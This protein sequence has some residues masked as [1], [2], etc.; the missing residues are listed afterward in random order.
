MLTPEMLTHLFRQPLKAQVHLL[1]KVTNYDV[2]DL[3][4]AASNIWRFPRVLQPP[5]N[6]S[7]EVNRGSDFSRKHVGSA[8]SEANMNIFL[9]APHEGMKF[10]HPNPEP[11]IS[12]Q[13]LLA[14]DDAVFC[15][16]CMAE[17][18]LKD[19]PGTL[20]W[21]WNDPRKDQTALHAVSNQ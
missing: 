18:V 13:T 10:V 20:T 5:Y 9:D 1:L 8:A 19:R 15:V 3:K 14:I 12:K 16:R 11:F 4:T 17:E 2:S 21:S 7:V 6:Q